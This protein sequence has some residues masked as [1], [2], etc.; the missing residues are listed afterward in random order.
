MRFLILV[1]AESPEI[2]KARKVWAETRD[3]AK[4]LE[5]TPHHRNVERQVLFGLQK[6]GLNNTLAALQHVRVELVS[7]VTLHMKHPLYGPVC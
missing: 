6:Y 3:P 2:T 4:A 5:V 1:A 7:T